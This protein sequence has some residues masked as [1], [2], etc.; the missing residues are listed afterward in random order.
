MNR[1]MFDSI[2]GLDVYAKTPKRWYVGLSQ[3]DCFWFD[4]I[5]NPPLHRDSPDPIKGY[6]RDLKERVEQSL[7]KRFIYMYGARKKLRFNTRKPLSK[8]LFSRKLQVN[9]LVGREGR[10]QSFQCDLS[11]L[12]IEDLDQ[13]R[14][15]ATDKFLNISLYGRPPIAIPIHD[16]MQMFAPGMDCPTEVHY[17]GLT[18]NPHRRPLGREHR[19]YGDMVYGVGAEDHDFFLYVALFKVMAKA[20]HQPSGFHFLVS[21]SMVDEVD[22]QKEGELIEG[23]FITY[24]DSKYQDERGAGERAKLEAQL[25]RVKEEHNI[26]SI[27]V[28]FEVDIPS[29]YYRFC[30]R[31]RPPAD[32]HVFR[33]GLDDNKLAL[34]VLPVTL[35]AVQAFSS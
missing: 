30:S 10:R 2:R 8:G 34:E 26:E 23:A 18:K 28:D 13:A 24:F 35:D 12:G 32:R 31:A 33:C 6:L 14:V 29:P 20:D 11:S 27:V 1:G 22:V 4:L 17:V 7:E 5:V 9:V 21:N 15:T 3:I 19:G 16:F 25:R